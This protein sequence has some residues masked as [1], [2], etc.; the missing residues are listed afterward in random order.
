[1]EIYDPNRSTTDVRQASPRRMNLRVLTIS[2]VAIVI[3]FAVIFA[4]FSVMQHA[5]G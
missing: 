5:P 2:L 1:M 3:A 4:V